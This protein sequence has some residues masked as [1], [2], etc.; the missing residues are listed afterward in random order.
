MVDSRR[1]ADFLGLPEEAA[2][3]GE[4]PMS[5]NW[6]LIVIPLAGLLLL[7]TIVYLIHLMSSCNSEPGELDITDWEALPRSM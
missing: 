1:I 5:V 7:F 4:Q 6:T 2:N 3:C